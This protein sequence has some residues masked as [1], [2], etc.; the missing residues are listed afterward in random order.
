MNVNYNLALTKHNVDKLIEKLKA[1]LDTGIEQ[2]LENALI[3]ASREMA[4]AQDMVEIEEMKK[5]EFSC[6]IEMYPMVQYIDANTAEEA[7]EIMEREIED[8]GFMQ[9]LDS[10]DFHCEVANQVKMTEEY[11]KYVD[12]NKIKLGGTK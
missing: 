9:D 4:Q 5:Y 1:E 3:Q 8:T 6:E 10:R 11:K 12:D 7:V 2:T